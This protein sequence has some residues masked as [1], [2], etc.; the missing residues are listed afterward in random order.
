[1]GAVISYLQGGITTVTSAI[2]TLSA[3]NAKYQSLLQRVHAGPFS[4]VE[5]PTVSYWMQ[6]PPFPEIGD[7]QDDLP[8]EA[9]VV[10]IGSGITGA[11]AAKTVLEL[12][13]AAAA[14]SSPAKAPQVVVLEARQLCSGATARNG[15]HIKCAPHEEFARLR[16]TLGEEKARKIVRMQMRH[17]E[18]LREVGAEMPWGEVREVETVDVCLERDVFERLKTSAG[19]LKEWMP[20]YE[21]EAWEADEARERFGV[22]QHVVGAVSYKAGALWPYRLVTSTWNDLMKRYPNLAVSTHTLVSSISSN[23]DAITAD[24]TPY[25]V[26]TSRGTLRAKHVLHA[27]NGYTGHLNPALRGCLTGVIGHM[28]AQ[29]PGKA[30]APACHGGR[31]WSVIYGNGFDYVT[32]RP[33]GEDG[34]AGELM[35]GGGLFRSKDEGLDQI[36]VWDDGRTDAFP[37]MH[38]RGS[39]ATIFEPKW[40]VGGELRGA[41]T[42]IMGFTGDMLPFV[43]SLPA[44]MDV[45]VQSRKSKAKRMQGGFERGASGQWLAAGFNGEGMVWAW[46]SGVAVA[47]MMLGL[48]EKDLEKAVGRPG[49]RLDEWYP[50]EEVRVDAARLRRADLTN[51]AGEV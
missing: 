28:T 43:G 26:H 15:G 36:G 39:M 13:S 31:S 44:E 29:R 4:P 7:I 25:T 48:E 27:T 12:S 20:E 30:F 3:L 8:A 22:N 49:G 17:L 45:A 47:I 33:D 16:R 21:I 41:W 37:L 19:E 38:L 1:M 2:R 10:I 40:G 14:S 11:A 6:N 42:G 23:S 50:M 46:L 35:L 5:N 24:S 9:D 51:L 18:V 32:Q 34:S